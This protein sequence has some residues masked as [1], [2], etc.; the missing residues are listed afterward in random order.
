MKRSIPDIGGAVTIRGEMDA[1]ERDVVDLDIQAS[2]FGTGL[3][4]TGSA[5][6]EYPSVN[7]D[8]VQLT[9]SLDALGGTLNLNP[10]YDLNKRAPDAVVGY[11]YGPTSFKVDAQKKQLTVAHG[12]N[13]NQISPTVSA[14]GDFSLSYS[15]ELADG[16]LTTTWTPDDS[17][18]V[19]WTDGGWDAT[20][21][22]PLEGYYNTNGGLKVSMKRNIDVPL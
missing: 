8:K 16:K 13:G 10:S 22:A 7:V 4:V 1:N 21:V 17:I 19:Q 3:R 12:F 14:G 18:K 5:G 9:K 11:S 6:I 15:R 20:L 2:G